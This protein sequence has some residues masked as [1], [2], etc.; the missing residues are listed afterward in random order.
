[1]PVAADVILE[2]GVVLHHRDL[3]NLYGCRIGRDTRIGPFVEIQR[4]VEVGAR[5][6]ISSHSFLCEGVMLEDDVFV[7]HGVMFINDKHPKAAVDGRL[8]SEADWEVLRTRIGR[9]ASIGSGAVI[10]GGVTVG[11]DALIGAGAV[12][13]RD[14]APSAT[15]A[16]VPARLHYTSE[17]P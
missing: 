2:P 1:M 10:L 12:V 4:G 7:G 14:V 15:V 5:C 16:G 17:R 9:G 6:K 11:A 3:V 8:V 13:T